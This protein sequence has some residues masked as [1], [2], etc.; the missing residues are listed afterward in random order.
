MKFPDGL[1]CDVDL[2]QSTT[3]LVLERESASDV[4]L[5]R[6]RRR[7][8]RLVASFNSIGRTSSGSSWLGR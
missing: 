1:C 2:M 3:L 5:R 7:W 8:L 4:G 6:G